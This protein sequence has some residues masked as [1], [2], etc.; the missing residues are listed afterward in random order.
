MG[1]WALTQ[2]NGRGLSGVLLLGFVLALL[3]G[4]FHPLGLA[5]DAYDGHVCSDGRERHVEAPHDHEHDASTCSFCHLARDV[6]TDLAL[7]APTLSG[8]AAAGAA[9]AILAG[10]TPFAPPVASLRSRAPPPA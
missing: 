7:S 2:R 3:L 8:P 9:P 5:R 10:R 6:D 1:P 4:A